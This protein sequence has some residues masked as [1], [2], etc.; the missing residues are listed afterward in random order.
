MR[1]A[2]LLLSVLVWL[3]VLAVSA[4]RTE[5]VEG[6]ALIYPADDMTRAEA[7]AKVVE[8]ARFDALNREFGCN[9]TRNN[10]SIVSNDDQGSDV[11]FYMLGESDLRGIWLEDLEEPRIEERFEDGRH[12]MEAWVNGRAQERLQA[13]I[14]FQWRLLRNGTEERCAVDAD[15]AELMEGDDFYVK[16]CS[17]IK[18]YLLVFAADDKG[19]V[20]KMIPNQDADYCL[21]E[22]KK[23]TLF[24]EKSSFVATLPVNR[25][26]E[27]DQL[28]I[29]FSPKTLYPP[30]A[31]LPVNSDDLERYRNYEYVEQLAFKDFQKYLGKILRD[32]L[33][34]VEKMFV[35]I[36]KRNQ[37]DG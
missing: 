21:V 35:K 18:G 27:I 7:R 12:I 1:H 9:V 34:Q 29:I 28:Y 19:T 3:I 17:P 36:L 37:T 20:Y 26:V 30:V 5:K 6:H 15:Y 8:Q 31:K 24:P 23:W 14:T 10:F 4:Q 2:R 25:R 16:F 11:S 32:P 22:R 13:D 33:V